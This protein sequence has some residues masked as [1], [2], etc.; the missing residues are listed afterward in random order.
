MG[1]IKFV[2][3]LRELDSQNNATRAVISRIESDMADTSML[4]T[5]LI[6][7]ALSAPGGKIEQ[8]NKGFPYTFPFELD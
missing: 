7:H 3:S 1:Y 4:E 8:E 5:N 2:M 6:M